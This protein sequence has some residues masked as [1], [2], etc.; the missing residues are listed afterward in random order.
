MTLQYRRRSKYEDEIWQLRV[1]LCREMLVLL[2]DSWCKDPE[3][4]F[5][6]SQFVAR[7]LVLF[8]SSTFPYDDNAQ[9]LLSQEV[10]TAATEYS[11]TW[12]HRQDEQAA[13]TIAS[14][15]SVIQGALAEWEC[16][17]FA[18]LS[19]DRVADQLVDMVVGTQY[20]V[21]HHYKTTK[22]G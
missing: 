19:V 4:E 20:V 17:G 12:P 9:S 6:V 13:E 18:G 1:H 10:C 15:T 8:R 5:P 2:T 11:T 14:L 16:Q 3:S 22:R 7:L 21:F